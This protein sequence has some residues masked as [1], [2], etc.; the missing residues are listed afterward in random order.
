MIKKVCL[1]ILAFLLLTGAGEW[2]AIV[3]IYRGGNVSRDELH[4][5]SAEQWVNH[6]PY[7]INRPFPTD[8]DFPLFSLHELLFNR[9]LLDKYGDEY[10]DTPYIH[11]FTHYYAAQFAYNITSNRIYQEVLPDLSDEKLREYYQK[12]R[13]YFLKPEHVS[14]QYLLLRIEDDM[15]PSR[16]EEQEKLAHQ[17]YKE[18]IDAPDKF[19]SLIQEY[20]DGENREEKGIVRDLPLR[21]LDPDFKTALLK[22]DQN[23]ISEPVHLQQG[24]F[25]IRLLESREAEYMPFEEAEKYIRQMIADSER[26][27][28]FKEQKE[29]IFHEYMKDWEPPES[30]DFE[31]DYTKPLIS[32]SRLD[33]DITLEKLEWAL[34]PHDLKKIM[35]RPVQRERFLRHIAKQFAFYFHLLDDEEKTI[36]QARPLFH[37]LVFRR[38][39]TG[40]LAEDIVV[41]EE[42]ARNFYEEHPNRFKTGHQYLISQI[43]VQDND[44]EKA[45]ATIQEAWEKLQKGQSFEDVAVEYSEDQ[46]SDNKG[47]VGWVS[48]PSNPDRDRIMISLQ[49]GEFS[50]PFETSR[51][52]MILYRQDNREPQ[53]R[54]F[55]EVKHIIME[56]LQFNKRV[57]AVQDL[58]KE[59][60]EDYKVQVVSVIQ[61][62]K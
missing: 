38:Y 37:E 21:K 51:G 24:F 1:A 20:S 16:I 33:L 42:E 44:S 12:N 13:E 15:S 62:L 46:Y 35:S 34:G 25:I 18:A 2:P 8:P 26:S 52:Y 31:D 59:L 39:F 11:F 7:I 61:E 55:E 56:Q 57:M 41:S 43:T 23:E 58:K 47:L 29:K 10:Q 28:L 60:F 53:T 45:E 30:L 17:L 50:E 6:A 9:L 40:K 5:F 48:R 49:N 54:P 36:L 19:G 4:L 3:A 32:M 22:L 14:I 27:V